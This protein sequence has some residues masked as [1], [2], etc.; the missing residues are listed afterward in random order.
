[1]LKHFVSAMVAM[2]VLCV[3][4]HA[5]FAAD[6]TVHDVYQTAEAGRLQEAQTMMQQVLRDHPESAKAHY[7]EAELYAKA[8]Q[9]DYARRELKTAKRLDP[10]LGFA[11]QDAVEALQA[12]LAVDAPSSLFRSQSGF[13]WGYL[14]VGLGLIAVIAMALRA[15]MQRNAVPAATSY[16]QSA[17]Y[18]AYSPGYGAPGGGPVGGMGSGILGGLAT[19]AAV[20]AGIVAGEALAN[21]FM[22]GGHSADRLSAERLDSAQSADDWSNDNMGGNDFGL[23]D[24]SSWDD[25]SGGGDVGGDWS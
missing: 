21:R 19:G 3:S 13:P 22:D 6:Y 25:S 4:Q 5:A 15:L 11:K 14:L 2:I 9:L 20:G 16:G 12:R 1:M 8:G 23:D 17:P 24:N 7:V 18:G 10:T